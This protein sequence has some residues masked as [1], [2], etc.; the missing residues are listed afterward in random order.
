[1]NNVVYKRHEAKQSLFKGL[2]KAL[3]VKMVS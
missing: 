1:M 2:L 3:K